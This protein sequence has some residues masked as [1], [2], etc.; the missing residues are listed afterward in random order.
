MIALRWL[1][2]L[3]NPRSPARKLFFSIGR[4]QNL[5]SHACVFPVRG[6]AGAD[7]RLRLRHMHT[8]STFMISDLSDPKSYFLF[9][10][11]PGSVLG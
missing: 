5:P 6:E 1:I 10:I 2:V 9:Q 3:N 7:S 8:E 4:S 11:E